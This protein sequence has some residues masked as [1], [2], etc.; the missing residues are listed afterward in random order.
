MDN[1]GI[2]EA[3]GASGNAL[4][5]IICGRL[6][7]LGSRVVQEAEPAQIRLVIVEPVTGQVL[8]LDGALPSVAV[9]EELQAGMALGRDLFVARTLRRAA[10]DGRVVGVYDWSPS[11]AALPS[12]QVWVGS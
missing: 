11:D 4:D 9:G 2:I 5:A 10:D 12:G 3:I 1:E 8:L 7:A 6:A